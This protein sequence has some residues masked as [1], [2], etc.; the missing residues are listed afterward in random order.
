MTEKKLTLRLDF[1]SGLPIYTQIVN[2]IQSQLANGRLKPGD[3][4]PT[5]RALAQELRVNFNTVARAYRILDEARIISTQQGRGTY[6]TEI[7]PPNISEKLRN[8]SLEA[9]T[10]RFINEAF[11]LGFFEKEISQMVRD[12]LK[13]RKEAQ[14]KQKENAK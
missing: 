9:L 13:V 6:I 1:H 7:P 10:Q 11:R 2:Q 3:Q 14:N 12:S 8:E 4:L 5:V